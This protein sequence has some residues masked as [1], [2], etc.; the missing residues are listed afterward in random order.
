MDV[1]LEVGIE[2]GE[3]LLCSVD[4]D[5]CDVSGRSSS[6]EMMGSSFGAFG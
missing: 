2:V 6:V 3:L 5:S 1:E 4:W